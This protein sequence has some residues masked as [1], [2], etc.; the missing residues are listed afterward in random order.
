M[1]DNRRSRDHRFLVGAD[2][3]PDAPSL[4]RSF[5]RPNVVVVHR[6]GELRVACT[7]DLAT[8]RRA[9]PNSTTDAVLRLL[10]ALRGYT[11]ITQPEIVQRAEEF[12]GP[13]DRWILRAHAGDDLKRLH[14][15]VACGTSD[16]EAIVKFSRLPGNHAVFDVEADLLRSFEQ[17][18]ADVRR[19]VPRLLGHGETRNGER[20]NVEEAV[21]VPGFGR[22]V[23]DANQATERIDA[24]VEWLSALAGESQ[25]TN[26]ESAARLDALLQSTGASPFFADMDIPSVC[27]HNDLGTWNLTLRDEGFGVVDWE[28]AERMGFPIWD[29]FYFL[30]DV[31]TLPNDAVD[32][33]VRRAMDILAGEGP[34]AADF[35][36]Y[37][38]AYA[39]RIGLN[40][41]AIKPLLTTCMIHHSR[42]LQQ[43]SER[44]DGLGTSAAGI[45]YLHGELLD[46]F[47]AD[48]R[49]SRGWAR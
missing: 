6:K 27:A 12:C 29:L 8:L 1:S 37:L 36:Q 35:W 39:T 42:S 43:R 44:G 4:S 47:L 22:A 17:Y 49:F 20:F 48:G 25:V 30:I 3:T 23:Q 31:F 21:G 26:S 7:S 34:K 46:A 28:G 13:L 24:V 16:P 14:F 15:E 5:R 45:R 10:R 9:F 19:P 11:V 38:S 40:E 33:R 41:R 18:T 2:S 32:T